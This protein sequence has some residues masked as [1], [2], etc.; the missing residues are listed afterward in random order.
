MPKKKDRKKKNRG[1]VRAY[2]KLTGATQGVIKGSVTRS[3]H[4]DKIEVYGWSHEVVSPRDAASGLPTGKRQ[5]KPLVIAK[6]L[7]R[8]TPLLRAALVN[9]ETF[10]DWRLEAWK[11]SRSGKEFM[12]YSIELIN[13]SVAGFAS[14]ML[15]DRV[16]KHRHPAR[17]HV[18]FTYQK[19]VWTWEDGAVTAEDDWETPTS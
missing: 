1:T 5:H 15:D 16:E 3:R 8:S 10:T 9:H 2:L 18:S 19:I 13:A 14:E 7:D 6:P 4:V 11:P 12:F 17:E